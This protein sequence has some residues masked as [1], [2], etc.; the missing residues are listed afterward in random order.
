MKH[1]LM[2]DDNTTNLKVA[3]SVLSPYYQLSMAKSGKQALTFLKKNRP[4]LILLDIK[5]P[6]MDGYQTME[7][8]KLN[9]DIA[10][11]PIIFLTADNERT[12]EIK[13]LQM[14]ALDFIT[15]PFEE[16]VM[17]GRI[18]K[19]LMME[20]MR[21]NLI[22]DNAA[23]PCSEILDNNSFVDLIDEKLRT[24]TERGVLYLIKVDDCANNIEI[25]DSI[26]DCINDDLVFGRLEDNILGIYLGG[27][28]SYENAM[29]ISW[30]MN[31]NIDINCGKK[32]YIGGV[33][34]D[35]D[36]NFSQVRV[37]AEKALYYAII[38]RIEDC[39]IYKEV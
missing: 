22:S 23:T 36:N 32:S 2:V 28:V 21:R 31:K 11:I 20:D 33:L 10:D 8:I 26:R 17:L 24:T 38:N 37:K 18:E 12:S 1:I 34:L 35:I 39:H 29:D 27:I 13:G 16:A 30:K 6:E 9:P 7:E 3:A 19:V 14:G 25:V 4:D 5:M 15:K